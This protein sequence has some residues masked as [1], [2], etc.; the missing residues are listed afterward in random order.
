MLASGQE[1]V[2]PEI[3]EFQVLDTRLKL[4]VMPAKAGLII[5]R[6]C[7]MEFLVSFWCY[8]LQP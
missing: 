2:D 4:A 5:G 6:Y 3:V 1:M 8:Y 7:L